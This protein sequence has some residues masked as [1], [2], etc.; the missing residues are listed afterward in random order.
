MDSNGIVLRLSGASLQVIAVVLMT[1]LT[2]GFLLPSEAAFA[3]GE[4]P[5]TERI[6]RTPIGGNPWSPER[7]KTGD[8]VVYGDDDRFDVYEETDIQRLQWAASTC[9]LVSEFQLL[10]NPD[11]SFFLLTFDYTY[12]GLPACD[13][14]P[15]GDQPTGP[16]CTGFM[17]GPDL[18]ATAGHCFDESD[19][20][21][22]RFLFGFGMADETLAVTLFPPEQIYQG[23]EI[24][25]RMLSGADDY[26]VIRVDRPITAQNAVPFNI[27]R[28]G[29]VEIGENVGVI[30]HPSGLPLKIAFGENTKVKDN[31]ADEY[32]TA[33]LDA[34]GG[35]SGAPVINA[36]TGSVE[37]ILVRGTAIQFLIDGNCFVS[38]T[39]PDEDASIYVDS[40]KSSRFVEFI[41][42]LGLATGNYGF[43]ALPTKDNEG[44]LFVSL[45]WNN[46]AEESFTRAVVLR[47][48]QGFIRDPQ[49][50]T[51]IYQGKDASFLDTN[52]ENGV[53]Y[54]YTLLIYEAGADPA[55]EIVSADYARAMTGAPV[56][57][58]WAE[59]FGDGTTNPSIRDRIDL[60]YSQ[61][62]FSPTGPPMAGIDEDALGGDFTGYVST[63]HKVD[64]SGNPV[65]LPVAR[66]DADG[67]AW[68]LT[69][70]DDG[71]VRFNAGSAPFTLFGKHYTTLY[72]AANG[73]IVPMSLTDNDPLNYITGADSPLEAHFAVPRISFLFAD[74]VPTAGGEIWARRLNDRFVLT[75][76][77]IPEYDFSNVW[78]SP[79]P[80][81]VQLEFFDSGHIRFTYQE[82]GVKNAVVGLSD[83]N[84]LPVDPAS[85]HGN[86]DNSLRFTDFSE[87]P[88][89]PEVLIFDV[90][91]TAGSWQY[92][93]AGETLSFTASTFVPTGAESLP[94]L[95]GEWLRAEAVPFADNRD[96]TGSFQWEIPDSESGVYTV[97][98]N[99]RL[100]SQQA[101]QDV[102]VAIGD[103]F[104]LPT[105][106]DLEV[107]S[108]TP[109]EDPSQSRP[110]DVERPLMA[111]YNYTHPWA[112]ERP[113][114]YGE[115]PSL[116]YWFRNG[117]I[118][119]SMTNQLSVPAYATKAN[120]QWFFRVMPVTAN[121]LAGDE[122]VSPIVTIAG[123]PEIRSVTPATG[124]IRGGE[125][126]QIA[127]TRLGGPL[128]VTFGGVAAADVRAVNANLIEVLTP[129][130]PQAAVDVVVVTVGG[131][132]RV[133]DAF[134]F[135]DKQAPPPV[136]NDPIKWFNC[137]GGAAAPVGG[138]RLGDFLFVLAAITLVVLHASRG[139]LVFSRAGVVFGK[140]RR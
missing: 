23:V 47:S 76:E 89:E 100:D 119:P 91:T 44:N 49:E 42:E 83:G 82:L 88:E 4:K 106:I 17:V 84:G 105:A 22:A 58:I 2:A 75:F 94:F 16:F 77:G 133:E 9:G 35:N 28:E 6:G 10:E 66:E 120:D 111:S 60:S 115:G 40:S 104:P 81:T 117:Q 43:R 107:S 45:Q 71:L 14:E 54:F 86:L 103:T 132:G 67:G 138:G 11:G 131:S 7:L 25:G 87:R 72:V 135:E 30:G 31:T 110:V 116:L 52:V 13:E 32:F 126:I 123:Y 26:A 27:R 39:F 114:S 124:D 80:N 140:A 48:V 62:L 134:L 36:E 3:D 113:D 118:V 108:E 90:H 56:A 69:M 8:K 121:Y 37:G 65:Q 127:G 24:V 70:A 73:Y 61:I 38:T 78:T 102:R 95:S 1:V 137:A 122:V 51:P 74:L 139:G 125:W 130:H 129:L 50:G 99:A 96:G 41:A 5:A 79:L 101:Y 34:Q 12:A 29:V 85:V 57:D 53:E 92:A 98:V 20:E 33:N 128:S 64:Q 136:D 97:R 68:I 19:L 18:I 109:Y 93:E 21:S 55:S 63:F 46:P 112:F 15:Y 59:S